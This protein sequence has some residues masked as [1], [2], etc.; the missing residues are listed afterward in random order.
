[1]TM[2]S[3]SLTE[4]QIALVLAALETQENVIED[5]DEIPDDAKD[6]LLYDVQSTQRDIRERT[7]VPDAD[8]FACR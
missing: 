5:D 8:L 3:F 1:M 6:L 4:D 7:R 2:R